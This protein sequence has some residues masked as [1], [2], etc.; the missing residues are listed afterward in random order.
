MPILTLRKEQKLVS[1]KFSA[2]INSYA[3]QNRLP[4]TSLANFTHTYEK[5][6][7]Q[8]VV[9]FTCRDAGYCEECGSASLVGPHGG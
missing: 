4:H 1:S 8:M 7:F 5:C 9:A 3:A 6:G 2:P